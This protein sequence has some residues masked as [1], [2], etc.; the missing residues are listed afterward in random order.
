VI[1]LNLELASVTWHARGSGAGHERC[2]TVC[3]CI[4]PDLDGYQ[5]TKNETLTHCPRETHKG[6]PNPSTKPQRE[7]CLIGTFL[8]NSEQFTFICMGVRSMNA[9][10]CTMQFGTIHL[11]WPGDAQFEQVTQ[12]T[13]GWAK[14]CITGRD[15]ATTCVWV[16]SDRVA[17]TIYNSC[18]QPTKPNQ[19]KPNQT[20]PNQ[21]KPNQTNQHQPFDTFVFIE[22]QH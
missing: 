17:R 13:F 21:T 6:S 5:G 16:A 9:E 11:Y 1:V 7:R 19:T 20:K 18:N 4:G 12:I 3:L 15:Q 10:H 2:F 22:S 14:G 8:N